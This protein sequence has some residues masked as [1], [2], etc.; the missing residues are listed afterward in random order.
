MRGIG[1]SASE[2]F[3]E[4]LASNGTWGGICDDA[5]DIN[6]ATVICQML[7][8][9][10]AVWAGNGWEIY[11]GYN[12]DDFVLDDLYCTGNEKSIFDCRRNGLSEWQENC[13]H[14]EIAGVRCALTKT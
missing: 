8:Y 2:G 1:S 10:S 3:V 13:N 5:W 9:P 11:P 6:D 14:N 7:G 12:S 4:V